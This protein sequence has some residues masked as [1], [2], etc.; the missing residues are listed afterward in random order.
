MTRRART[1]LG[2]RVRLRRRAAA[3]AAAALAALAPALAGC[4]IRGTSVPVDAGSAPSRVSCKVPGPAA[5]AVPDGAPVKVYL[6]CSSALATVDRTVTVP[7]QRPADRLQVAGDLLDELQEQPGT[8]EEEAGF[9]TSVPEDLEVSAPRAGDPEGTLRLSTRPED[10]PSFALAQIVC[11]FGGSAALGGTDAAVL[12]GP[13]DSHPLRY[14]CTAEVRA[15]PESA[16]STGWGS[17]VPR[18]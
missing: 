9:S 1:P 8:A 15:H 17:P 14:A 12:G 7:K 10:L 11:T 2:S 16:Q 6:V 18:E 3:L 13:G 5:P 4:G